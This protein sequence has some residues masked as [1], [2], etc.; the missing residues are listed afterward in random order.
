M[1]RLRMPGAARVAPPP[2]PSPYPTITRAR[3]H[4]HMRAHTQVA[5]RN[6]LTRP[7][8]FPPDK[9]PRTRPAHGARV[10]V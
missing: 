2:G 9:V 4:T 3:A 7:V 8:E 6:L 1:P 5:Y 10:C